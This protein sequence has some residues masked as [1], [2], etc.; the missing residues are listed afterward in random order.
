ML[1]FIVFIAAFAQCV[2]ITATQGP[3]DWIDLPRHC[4]WKSRSTYRTEAECKTVRLPESHY[5]NWSSVAVA[6]FEPCEVKKA[7]SPIKIFC[8][9]AAALWTDYCGYMALDKAQARRYTSCQ[10]I[11]ICNWDDMS[12]S[13]L[14][15]ADAAA[16]RVTEAGHDKMGVALIM[17]TPVEWMTAL[18]ADKAEH[19]EGLRSLDED[20]EPWAIVDNKPPFARDSSVDV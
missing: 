13:C 10:L 12:S 11:A 17:P 18:L 5:H 16:M 2:R 1:F 9:P 19:S 8:Q 15:T 14:A 6:A 3:S 7:G 20:S 4:G